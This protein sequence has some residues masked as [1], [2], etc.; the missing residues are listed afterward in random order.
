MDTGDTREL[1]SNY[2]DIR[3]FTAKG[4]ARFNCMVAHLYG[5]QAELMQS[6]LTRLQAACLK[7]MNVHLSQGV[8]LAWEVNLPGEDMPHTE[9]GKTAFLFKPEPGD[10]IV[11]RCR[12][13]E[14]H[15]SYPQEVEVL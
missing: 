14:E 5:H 10:L 2:L 1:T 9:L 11:Q 8:D 3:A 12:F 7:D 13:Y 15:R 6:L 4:E